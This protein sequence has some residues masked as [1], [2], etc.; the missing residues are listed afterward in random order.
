MDPTIEPTGSDLY[1]LRGSHTWAEIYEMFPRVT[2]GSL[3]GRFNRFRYKTG[4]PM[5]EPVISGGISSEESLE[6]G[7]EKYREMVARYRKKCELASD[8]SRVKEVKFESGPICIVA[9]AD[10][11][12]GSMGVDYPRLAYE[13]E[14]VLDA[15]GMFFGLVGD[16]VDNFIVGR[17][18]DIH[19]TDG[20]MPVT[21]EWNMAKYIVSLIAPKLLFSVAGNHDNWTYAVS[22]LDGVRNIHDQVSSGILYD[23]DEL[24]FRLTVGDFSCHVHA[25]HSWRGSS[26]WN[27]THGLEKGVVFKN[28]RPTNIVIGAHTHTSGLAREFNNGDENGLA[29]LCGSYKVEDSFAKRVGFAK[30]NGNTA[31]AVVVDDGGICFGTSNLAAAA[32]YMR[33]IYGE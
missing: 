20:I 1:A 33:T 6:R 31:V 14:T 4:L 2:E 11:H 24:Y 8:K 18:K 15:P 17:L 25:R 5:P 28:P 3:R 12:L 27:D 19:I 10:L 26:Q 7:E 32:D 21:D 13:I 29:L 16:L 9:I 22:G 23:R 30:P